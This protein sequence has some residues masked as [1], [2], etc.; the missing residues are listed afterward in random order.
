MVAVSMPCIYKEKEAIK[1]LRCLCREGRKQRSFD[2]EV[3][4]EA[5]AG[6]EVKKRKKLR[7]SLGSVGSV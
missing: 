6:K 5:L 4:G 3:I 2:G 7:S 1:T